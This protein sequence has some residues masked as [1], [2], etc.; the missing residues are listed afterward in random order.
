MLHL[1]FRH[2]LIYPCCNVQPCWIAPQPPNAVLEWLT[3]ANA[4]GLT[5]EGASSQ[6]V[7]DLHP[8]LLDPVNYQC[9]NVLLVAVKDEERDDVIWCHWDVQAEIEKVEL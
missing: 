8:K 7:L 9:H 3:K 5:E 6:N 4:D 1:H 2:C